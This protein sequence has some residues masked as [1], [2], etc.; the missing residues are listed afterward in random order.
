M[1]KEVRVHGGWLAYRRVMRCHLA[2]LS[3]E[4]SPAMLMHLC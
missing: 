2:G 3:R 1:P 4:V